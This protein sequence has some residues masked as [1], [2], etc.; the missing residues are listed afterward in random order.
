MT[1]GRSRATPTSWPFGNNEQ[2]IRV[3]TGG[4]DSDRRSS[5]HG[6]S[7]GKIFARAGEKRNQA[8]VR[9]REYDWQTFC[10]R[11]AETKEQQ[12]QLAE[13]DAKPEVVDLKWCES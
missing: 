4:A 2:A 10:D 13:A 6:P 11:R 12:R 3:S 7:R 9:I 1:D 5:C 8:S